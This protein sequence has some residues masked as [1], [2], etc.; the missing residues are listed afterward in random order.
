MNTIIGLGTLKVEVLSVKGEDMK[1]F[2]QV[3]VL[4]KQGTRQST[5]GEYHTDFPSPYGDV[6]WYHGTTARP[7]SIINREGLTPQTPNYHNTL[8][9]RLNP[10]IVSQFPTGVYATSNLE[11]AQRY[12]NERGQ[13]RNEL[14]QVY[15]IREGVLETPEDRRVREEVRFS[16]PIPRKYLVPVRGR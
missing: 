13:D 15:G 4:L 9:A 5:L 7:S 16:E 11:D 1:P 2:D 10:S 6:L 3:W 14:G 12:A 8:S